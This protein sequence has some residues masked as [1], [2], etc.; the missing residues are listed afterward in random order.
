MLTYR[1]A[2]AG[3][4]ATARVAAMRR[5]ARCRTI[6]AASAAPMGANRS[7]AGTAALSSARP[8]PAAGIATIARS[9]FIRGMWTATGPATAPALAGH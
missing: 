2:A 5:G 4:A 6:A 1:L 8:S 7:S 9:A 3:I